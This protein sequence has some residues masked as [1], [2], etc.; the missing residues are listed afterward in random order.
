MAHIP[1]RQ[2]ILVQK[3]KVN[4]SNESENDTEDEPNGNE[5]DIMFADSDVDQALKE[6]DVQEGQ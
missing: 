6:Y 3:T 1:I 4:W 2:L 5:E